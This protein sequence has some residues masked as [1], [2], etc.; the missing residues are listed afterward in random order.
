MMSM[1]DIP[2]ENLT[3]SPAFVQQVRDLLEHLYDFVYLQKQ[4][5]VLPAS[6]TGCEIVR[7]GVSQLAAMEHCRFQLSHP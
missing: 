1:A 5:L 4:T 7:R 6:Q 2:D 3:V